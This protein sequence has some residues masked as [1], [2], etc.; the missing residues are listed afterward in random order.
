MGRSALLTKAQ[1][2]RPSPALKV[3][4]NLLDQFPGSRCA[5]DLRDE[6]RGN[7]LPVQATIRGNVLDAFQVTKGAENELESI[8]RWQVADNWYHIRPESLPKTRVSVYRRPGDPLV[9][10]RFLS[11][12]VA[13]TNFARVEAI[14][15][16][17]SAG[18][19]PPA[20]ASLQGDWFTRL[21]ER[22]K[23]K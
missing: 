10:P 9:T 13:H 19:L 8:A 2:K 23:E 17:A 12:D 15:G 21:R 20:P 5:A 7:A 16:V 14:P 11:E 3:S 4:A 1:A 6:I 22:W 18:A